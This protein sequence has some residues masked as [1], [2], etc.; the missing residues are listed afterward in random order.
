VVAIG[1]DRFAVLRIAQQRQRGKA[2][3]IGNLLPAPLD[4]QIADA[5]GK[6]KAYQV[7]QVPLAIDELEGL[8]NER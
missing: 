1:N 4:V 7:R 3:A 5:K 2:L 6:A 8:R